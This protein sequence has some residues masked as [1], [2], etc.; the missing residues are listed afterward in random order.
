[1]PWVV[2][3]RTPVS[4]RDT[5]FDGLPVSSPLEGVRGL[6]PSAAAGVLGFGANG[7]PVVLDSIGD[8]SSHFRLASVTKIL[9]AMSVWI[10]VEEGTVSWE[11]P[12]GPPGSRL[13]DLLSHASGLAPD[14]DQIL[15]PPRTRRIYSNRGIEVAA[16][17]L[18]DR[19]GMPFVDY[20]S[21]GLLDP[22]GLAGVRLEGSPAHGAT[23]TL[24]DVLA[25]GAELLE[26][27]LVSRATVTHCTQVAVPGLSG[28]LP[29]FGRQ[30]QNDWG[31]GVE[32]RDHKAPHWTGSTNSAST[33]GHFG[34]SGCF[35]WVDPEV[36][37]GMAVLTGREFGPWAVDAWPALSDAV[38][39]HY[40][41]R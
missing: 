11:D 29:G 3:A 20:L 40:G 23:A 8:R 17:H 21:A 9:T 39:A 27:T 12:V 32:I 38:I 33:F 28:V 22:L 31:L 13:S 36:A 18:S 34:Q 24:D 25:V 10:A 19:S 4:D 37:L 16:S 41:N 35:L 14:G 7:G 26:P 15:A 30:D 5:P 2:P 1:M 6:A